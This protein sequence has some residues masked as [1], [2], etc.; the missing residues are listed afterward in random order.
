[1]WWQWLSRW[2]RRDERERMIGHIRYQIVSDECWGG[3]KVAE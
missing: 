3:P 1:M 2:T